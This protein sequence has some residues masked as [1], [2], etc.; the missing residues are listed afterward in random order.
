[1]SGYRYEC[2]ADGGATWSWSV[3]VGATDPSGRIAGVPNSVQYICRAYASNPIGMSPAS[4]VSDAVMPCGSL[5]ECNPILQPV[6]AVLGALAAA[7]LLAIFVMFYRRRPRGYVVAVVDVAHSIN[8]GSGS[9]LGIEVVRDPTT[10]A[11]TGVVPSRGPKPDIRIRQLRG[12]R[13]EVTD[14]RG[15]H[16]AEAGEPIVAV[17]AN[18]GRHQLVLHPFDR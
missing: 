18:G 5:L 12:G 14:K 6:V 4:A 10:R 1:V 8:L 7:G 16:V 11:V 2:S 3:Q 9:R 13:F 15:R 17:D